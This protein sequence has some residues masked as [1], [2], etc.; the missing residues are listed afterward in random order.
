MQT[1]DG[2]RFPFNK[3]SGLKF[4]KNKPNGTV[5]SGCTDPTQATARLVI[6]LVTRIQKSGT[7]NNFVKRKGTFRSDRPKCPD[8]SLWTTF[9]AG[10]EYNRNFRNF[11]LNGKRP[12]SRVCK[13]VTN[14]LNPY[15][16]YIRLCKHGKRFLLPKTPLLS[17]RRNVFNV[18]FAFAQKP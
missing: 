6:V 18:K 5:H 14:S 8:R 11:G 16:V 10:P 15:R 12:E 17:C 3:N 13:T 1:R 2:G 9:K 4:R 7:G